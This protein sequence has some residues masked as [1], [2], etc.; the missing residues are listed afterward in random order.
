MVNELPCP[1][2]VIYA[3]LQNFLETGEALLDCLK[4]VSL[5]LRSLR[6]IKNTQVPKEAMS[7]LSEA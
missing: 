4:N 3:V 5:R 6:L 2:A 1:K 7:E